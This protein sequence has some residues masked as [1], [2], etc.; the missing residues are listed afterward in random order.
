M[1]LFHALQALSKHPTLN[2]GLTYVEAR[3]VYFSKFD[4]GYMTSLKTFQALLNEWPTM[5]VLF[6]GN[7][8][9]SRISVN[10]TYEL[11]TK[12]L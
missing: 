11:F 12:Y 10:N 7:I 2:Y 6:L 9:L 5:V 8:T 3:Y 4:S 1:G